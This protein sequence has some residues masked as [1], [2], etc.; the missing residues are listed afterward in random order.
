MVPKAPLCWLREPVPRIPRFVGPDNG[1]R[2]VHYDVADTEPVAGLVN[3]GTALRYK[4]SRK[5]GAVG[6][7]RPADVATGAPIEEFFVASA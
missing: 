2:S 3:S 7:S 6:A 1:A 5:R 4:C